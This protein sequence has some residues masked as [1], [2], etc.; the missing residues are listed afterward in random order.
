MILASCEFFVFVGMDTEMI[1]RAIRSYYKETPTERSPDSYL[2]K[3]VQI[4]FYFLRP[5]SKSALTT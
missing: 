5:I 2:R 4:S 3:I 1:Y